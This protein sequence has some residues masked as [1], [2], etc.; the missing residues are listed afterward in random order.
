M[1]RIQE[2][3]SNVLSKEK[4]RGISYYDDL[5]GEYFLSYS[6]QY[7]EAANILSLLQNVYHLKKGSKLIIQFKDKR[8][9]ISS[10]W[11]CI[12]GG[13]VSVP[14][15]NNGTLGDMERFTNV[16]HELGN[17]YVISSDYE[18]AELNT[19]FSEMA[20]DKDV[21]QTK[22]IRLNESNIQNAVGKKIQ[23]ETTDDM[24]ILFSSGSTGIPKGVVLDHSSV[25]EGVTSLK[26]SLKLKADE[27]IA[28]WLPLSH[29]FGLITLHLL[30][31]IGNYTQVIFSKELFAYR[32]LVLLDIVSKYRVSLTGIPNFAFQSILN[33]ISEQD[34]LWDLSSLKCIINSAEP[35]NYDLCIEF[36]KQL[37]QYSFDEKAICPM[38]GMS[39]VAGGIAI[40]KPSDLLGI[41]GTDGTH[42]MSVQSDQ[43][44]DQNFACVI[45]KNLDACTIRIVSDDGKPLGENAI[46]NIEVLGNNVFSSYFDK[47]QNEEAFTQDGWFR[48][49]DVGALIEQKL[50]IVGRKKEVI[51]INGKKIYPNDIEKY[52]YDCLSINIKDVA[53]CGVRPFDDLSNEQMCV[54]V[55]NSESMESFHLLA[56]QIK[57]KL[58]A[59][60]IP[61]KCEV[62]P[63]DDIPKTSSGKKNR[64]ECKKQYESGKFDSILEQLKMMDHPSA[65]N[66]GQE[67]IITGIES[68]LLNIWKQ[69]LEVNECSI[70]DHFFEM[71]GNSINVLKMVLEA[72]SR[73]ILFKVSDVYKYPTIH[74]LSNIAD[75]SGFAGNTVIADFPFSKK[76][77]Y[78]VIDTVVSN[79]DTFSWDELSCFWRA[80]MIAVRTNGAYYDKAF[81]MNLLF[82]QIYQV[83]GFFTSPFWKHRDAEYERFF[84]SVIHEQ[85]NLQISPI[86][87]I[88]SKQ[89]LLEQIVHSI[90]SEHPLVIAG[91]LFTIFYANNYR[92]IPHFH[93]FVVKGYDTEK[94]I[95]YILDNIQLDNGSSTIYKDFMMKLDDLYETMMYVKSTMT[96]ENK[97]QLIWEYKKNAVGILNPKKILLEHAKLLTDIESGIKEIHYIESEILHVIQ[98]EK[99]S[100]FEL[101]YFN[102]VMNQKRTYFKLIASLM[103]DCL[104]CEKEI[105]EI[106][107]L[108][109]K[110]INLWNPVR[111]SILDSVF[112]SKVDVKEVK[113]II[114]ISNEY[115]IKYRKKILHILQSLKED[116]DQN[117][118]SDFEDYLTK[119]ELSIVNPMNAKIEYSENGVQ[120]NLDKK[121]R[122][123]FWI[124]GKNA[125]RIMRNVHTDEWI[126]SAT[127]KNLNEF[128]DSKFHDGIL[129]EFENGYHLLFGLYCENYHQMN[130]SIYCPK[131]GEDCRLFA[132]KNCQKNQEQLRVCGDSKL[133]C[134]QRYNEEMNLW[135]TLYELKV[136]QKVTKIGVFAKSWVKIKHSVMFYDIHFQ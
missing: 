101:E 30:A 104:I 19:Y 17:C 76:I 38:F 117:I 77:N 119:N 49:G 114:S 68:E 47:K 4:Q 107:Y 43:R 56:K 84:N 90:D 26:R 46:G 132:S 40:S 88:N 51:I 95:V 102:I 112:G 100:R 45:G 3:I 15:E 25:Y 69:I 87:G 66:A 128:H 22:E 134:F 93:Y 20:Y 64:N 136:D 42:T 123:D 130:I 118:Q 59:Y 44:I 55:K 57:E 75:A 120:I 53:V 73:Q 35:V 92:E 106:E 89:E 28:S 129:V 2:I 63:V 12:L 110:I 65:S 83:D 54:Y 96:E 82:S 81:L 135:E 111:I 98:N 52:L 86:T 113:E 39:E 36:A 108:Q 103:K 41:V 74:Q 24:L 8:L 10:I 34:Y 33:D 1:N 72:K 131:G 79:N 14:L 97:Q 9:M 11:A 94:K 133:I 6:K 5:G 61:K 16:W 121:E 70:H 99:I 115:E 27:I 18:L 7:E 67:Q 71:G 80:A 124:Q 60:G 21:L 48:T 13:I 122:Y 78:N 32:P 31:V 125:P 109:E 29:S 62:I 91:D 127:V 50:A 23:I 126:F 105:R 85:L 37:K 58:I 116:G